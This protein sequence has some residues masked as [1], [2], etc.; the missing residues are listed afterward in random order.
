MCKNLA[1]DTHKSNTKIVQEVDAKKIAFSV[2]LE[3][4]PAQSKDKMTGEAPKFP[5]L[6]PSTQN[7][8]VEILQPIDDG[9]EA[10]LADLP[11]HTSF[12]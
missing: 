11:N 2:E 7:Q 1:T 6:K 3:N 5:W 12:Q 4:P 9:F 8:I 10:Q